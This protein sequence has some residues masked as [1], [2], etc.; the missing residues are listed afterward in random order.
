VDRIA[1]F[2]TVIRNAVRVSKR[3]IT[4]PNSRMCLAIAKILKDEGFIRDYAVDAADPVKPVLNVQ[5]RYLN[6]EAAIHALDRVSTSGCRR[7]T[8]LKDLKPHIGGL[9]ISILSTSKGVITDKQ[10]KTLAVSG[11]VIC[12]VW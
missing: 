12:R 9:G 11:E 6:G 3:S 4:Y 2:L 5:L 7:Y 8:K 1:D 10:A